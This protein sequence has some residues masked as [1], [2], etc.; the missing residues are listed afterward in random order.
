MLR[1][2]CYLPELL[3]G[4]KKDD[5]ALVID[6]DADLTGENAVEE[7]LVHIELRD[8]LG[9][10]LGL[11]AA[12]PGLELAEGGVFLVN[13]ARPLGDGDQGGLRGALAAARLQQRADE[14]N[15]LARVVD[16]RAP[17]SSPDDRFSPIRGF[18]RGSGFCLCRCS[19]CHSFSCH[20]C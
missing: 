17:S 19:S 18:R 3:A 8:A 14:D 9:G 2:G 4:A 16:D 5:V 15:R 13:A 6:I 1:R 12:G 20:G 11:R 10:D 7:S